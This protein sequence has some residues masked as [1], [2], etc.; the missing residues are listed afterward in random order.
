MAGAA[1]QGRG[2]LGWKK[3]EER[4]EEKKILY[5]RRLRRLEDGR[6]VKTFIAEKMKGWGNVNWWGSVG[7]C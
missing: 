6:L 2:D 3:L 1:I 5:G 7:Y 4:S